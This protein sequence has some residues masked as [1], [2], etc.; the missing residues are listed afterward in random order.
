MHILGVIYYI[1]E[2]KV[3]K[4]LDHLAFLSIGVFYIILVVHPFFDT[5]LKGKVRLGGLV[6][7]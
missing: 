3:D 4:K 6:N 2:T 5:Q 7:L 1:L